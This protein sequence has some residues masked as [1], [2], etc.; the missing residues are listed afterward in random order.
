VL[1]AGLGVGEVAVVYLRASQ[2]RIADRL[3]ARQGHYF[4][5]GI[6]WQP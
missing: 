4:K 1:L 2:G 6:F 5:V 3:A